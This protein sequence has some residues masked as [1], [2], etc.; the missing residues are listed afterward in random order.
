MAKQTVEQKIEKLNENIQKEETAIE[1]SKKKIKEWKSELKKLIAEKEQ[2][3]ANEVLKLMKEKGISES[4]L[5]E[6]ITSAKTKNVE[7]DVPT[8]SFPN[9]ISESQTTASYYSKADTN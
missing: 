7:E 8:A 9:D 6:Q 2:A 4:E 5:L 1:E 3:F